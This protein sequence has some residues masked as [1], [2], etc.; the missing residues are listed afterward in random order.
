M[1][2]DAILRTTTHRPWPL[3]RGPWIMVQIWHDLLFAH[4]P[5][6]PQVMRQHV[7]SELPLDIFEGQAWSGVVPFH[8]SNVRP[9]WVPPMPGFSRFPEL[10]VR[11][12]V[13]MQNKP[14]IY[15]FSL[16]AGSLA[17]VWA[18]R[19]FFHLPYF[20]AEIAVHVAGH[21]I[22]Y[23]SRRTRGEAELM[24][25]YRPMRPVQ[26]RQ[27]EDLGPLA[28]GALLPVHSP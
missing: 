6:P 1:D 5:L 20:H 11:T 24:A 27:R 12:Y 10:N 3:P 8:M 9:R 28:Y 15:F 17:A 22:T 13:T 18:A 14:G 25:S 16:D 2:A 23:E 19:A 26:L 7:P 4:W 21:K